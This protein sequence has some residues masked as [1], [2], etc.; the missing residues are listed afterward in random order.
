[1]IIHGSKRYDLYLNSVVLLREAKHIGYVIQLPLTIIYYQYDTFSSS[2]NNL[3][4]MKN[5]NQV[6]DF[7]AVV[8][9]ISFLSSLL[10]DLKHYA[11]C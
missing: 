9:D 4:I 6:I 3:Q 11:Y 10:E 2:F 5:K 7:K 8:Y 1:M